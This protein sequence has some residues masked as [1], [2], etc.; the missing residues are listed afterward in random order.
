MLYD[1]RP[2]TSGCARAARGM[3]SSTGTRHTRASAAALGAAHSNNESHPMPEHNIDQPEWVGAWYAAPTPVISAN[4]VGR[5]LRQIV[6]VA[7]GGQQVRLRLSNR[8]GS[9]PVS[10]R[11]VSVGK[12]LR[13]PAV[14]PAPQPVRFQGSHALTILPGQ[15]AISD[16]IALGIA[17]MRSLAITFFVERGEITNGHGVGLETSYISP[18]GDYTA[19]PEDA[20]W[21]HYPLQTSARWLLCGVDV[22]PAEPL[23]AVVAIGSSVTDGVGSTHGQHGSWPDQLAARLAVAGG[24]R[25][26]AVLNAG[27]SGNQLIG[28]G[29][30]GE[31]MPP[32]WGEPG[33]ARLEW[34]VLAQPGVRDL[35][36][37]IGSNDLRAGAS[38]DQLIAALQ[39]LAT[40]ARG[41]CRRVLG[42]TIL[43]GGYTPEQNAQRER[44]NAWVLEQGR[45]CF[46]AVFDFATPLC[47]PAD[48]ALLAPMCDSGDG[49]HPNDEGY[50]RMAEAVDI[51]QLSGRA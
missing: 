41:V 2:T 35:I 46:D 10:I 40:R 19:A 16:P 33:L 29:S 34:D 36:I 13:A 50:R 28:Q 23:G 21:M 17:A 49:V 12:L 37:H 45:T 14:W 7:A 51:R 15:D 30:P 26:M 5:T 32:L 4:V 18:L 3:P 31:G 44:V 20:A 25:L 22:L 38:A 6:R 1:W 48:H 43:P 9:E 47:D 24:D 27:I 42:T 11:S 8:Y 39:Q